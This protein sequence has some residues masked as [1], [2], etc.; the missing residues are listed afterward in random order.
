[1]SSQKFFYRSYSGKFGNA[2]LLW[3]AIFGLWLA[4]GVNNVNAQAIAEGFDN[5]TTLPAAGWS[6][7]NLSSPIGTTPRTAVADL[8]GDGKT[9]YMIVRADGGTPNRVTWWTMINGTPSTTSVFQWG[10]STDVFLSA[11]F[12]G[13]RKHDYTVWRPGAAGTAAFYILNSLT[14]TVRIEL[15]GQ[16]G[17]DLTIIGDYDGDGKA[18]PATYR[19][20]LAASPQSFF[21]YRGSLNNPGGNVTYIPW[22]AFNAAWTDYSYPGDF[23]GDGKFDVAVGRDNLNPTKDQYIVRLS[24]TGAVVW[25]TFG[26]IGNYSYPGDYDGDGKTDYCVDNQF[27]GATD[28]IFTILFSGGGY[29]SVPFGQITN[30]R[31]VQGDYDGDGKTDIAIWQATTGQFWVLQ[32]STG[33]ATVVKWGQ[34]GDFPIAGFNRH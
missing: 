18:D 19:R 2:F 13:D 32:S 4:I 16:T 1:M 33:A 30:T 10:L 29:T 26:E 24:S 17:D 25:T 5:I 3:S 34:S 9:D 15:F 12:D 8:N 20:G 28:R 6:Q 14:N 7:Q 23:D 11:D 27:S 21:Y 22:G 31:P